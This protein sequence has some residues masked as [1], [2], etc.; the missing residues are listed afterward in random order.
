VIEA[1]VAAG[2]GLLIG[3]FLNV[4]IYRWPRDLSVVRPRSYCP[5]CEQGIAWY[6]NLPVASYIALRGRC[7]SCRTSIPFRYPLVELLTGGAF[8][9]GVYALGLTGAALKFCVFAAMQIALLFSDLEQR[10]L[11]DEFTIGGAVIGVVFAAFVPAPGGLLPIFLPDTWDPRLVNVLEAAAGAIFLSA[12]LFGIGEMYYRIRRRE[13]LGFGDVK[14]AGMIAA[15]LGVSGALFT[16]VLGSV[17]GS[18][19]GLLYIWL[20]KKDAATYELPFGSFLA[21]AALLVA[22]QMG[23]INALFP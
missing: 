13:G 12:V 1:L 11:P 7:R 6:D 18:V 3:S 16:M 4:C 21:I 2:F 15:F 22:L 17:L 19:T 8:F 9:I 23:P 14:M 5:G 20:A 10:I